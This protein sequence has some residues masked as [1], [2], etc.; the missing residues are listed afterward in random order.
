MLRSGR[1]EKNEPKGCLKEE[2]SS[3]VLVRFQ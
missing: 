1:S 3:F 2:C